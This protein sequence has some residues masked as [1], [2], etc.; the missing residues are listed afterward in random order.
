MS[1]F[2]SE[3]LALREPLDL[4]ARNAEV[5]EA[6]LG[7]LPER[8]LRILD[9]ASGAGS[10]IAAMHAKF[11]QP[12]NWLLTDHDPALLEIAAERWRNEATGR[13]E[14]RQVDLAGDLEDL[15]L[16]D[17]D[18]VTTSAFLD[19]VSEEFLLRLTDV[20]VRAGKPFLASLTYDGRTAFE[21]S[22]PFDATLGAALNAHQ[23][24]DK[25]FG[26]A[27]G[28]DA[29]VR[30]T[31]LFEDRGYRVVRGPSDWRG[32]PSSPEFLLEFLRGWG[33]VGQEI[34]LEESSLDA[35]W[36]DRQGKIRSGELH[37]EVGHI[38]FAALPSSAL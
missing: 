11:S 1:G 7:R 32:G 24:S 5:E 6:F 18:A 37:V 38:D 34:G 35:W 9:L 10:T 30:A 26:P 36:G 3:W 8:P 14:T 29:A 21:P 15:P 4:V 23:K 33:R 22:H 12:V 31:G 16:A 27:L 17:V 13:L 28:P 20:I 25:G 19:L 2:S